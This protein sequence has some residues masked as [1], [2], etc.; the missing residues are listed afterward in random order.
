M[1][2]DMTAVTIQ[3]NKIVLYEVKDN[4]APW[5]TR[6][7]LQKEPNERFGQPN[8]YCSYKANMKYRKFS[9]QATKLYYK[10]I[11]RKEMYSYGKTGSVRRY[12]K[13]RIDC[14]WG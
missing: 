14:L 6:A 11:I 7:I 3:S 2:L 12:Q 9:W 13:A 1:H 10:A 4:K 8:F 5:A